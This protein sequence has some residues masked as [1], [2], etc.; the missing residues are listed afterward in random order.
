VALI[1]SIPLEARLIVL[2]V[3]GACIGGAVN[4][5]IYRLAWFPRPISPW[6]SPDPS[7]PPR[8]GWD[9]LPIVGWLGLRREAG[10]HGAG[11]WVRPMLLELLA[12]IGA[13]WLYWWEISVGGLLP[14]GVA[15]QLALPPIVLHLEFAA[16]LVLIAWMLAGSMID[17][18]EQ[19]IPDE[20]TIPGTL[21]GLLIA[22]AWP[23]SLLPEVA[24]IDR[25][26][27]FL[28]LTSPNA[29]PAW[30]NAFPHAGSAGSLGLGLAC[31]WLW[32][33]ALLPRTW[34]PRHGWRRAWQLCWARVLRQRASYRLLKLA[35]IG[36]LAIAVVWFRNPPGW[37][38]LLTALVGM[39][40]GGGLMW[41]VRI[42]A[43]AMLHREAMGFGDVTLMAMIGAFL[44]W[45]PCLLVFFLAPFAGIVVG[46]LR[47]VLFRDREIP[48]GPF[49]CLAAL[50]VIVGWNSFWAPQLPLDAPTAILS[51]WYRPL[52]AVF[53]VRESFALGWIVPLL[54]LG[55]LVLM[56]AML[57]GW[58][59]IVR[60]F[61]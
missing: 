36:S 11:F 15:P 48:Y 59:L 3:L 26:L 14:S 61:R 9:R 29:W 20:I 32:C 24:P 52:G 23:W 56:A 5:A 7:A 60:A 46:V 30:L 45:Q 22:A 40:A 41:L 27:P 39:A 43:S 19:I 55:C 47:L 6:S 16:H 17:L 18:D 57:A 37:Q 1:L 58:R 25:G 4:L 8:R 28:H 50:L 54:M 34:Y 44:G 33:V 35:V 31:W 49:L 21:M 10:L 38:G 12:G 53:N 13:A 42:I 2:F 51:V